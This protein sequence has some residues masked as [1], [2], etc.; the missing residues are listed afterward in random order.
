LSHAA[1][2]SRRSRALVASRLR[3]PARRLHASTRPPAASPAL[4]PQQDNS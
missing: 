3:P 4:L 2:F 1:D